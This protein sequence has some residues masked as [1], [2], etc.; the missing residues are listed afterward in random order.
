MEKDILKKLELEY[1]L[2][3]DVLKDLE[4]DNIFQILATS[5]TTDIPKSL[6]LYD[7]NWLDDFLKE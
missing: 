3:K 5:A 4:N 6:T 7:L 1:L 2:E